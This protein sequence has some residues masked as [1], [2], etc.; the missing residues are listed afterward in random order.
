MSAQIY[1]IGDGQFLTSVI[2]SMALI[3]QSSSFTIL[4]ATGFLIGVLWVGVQGVMSGGR[5]FKIQ[6][7]FIAMLTWMVFFGSTTEAVIE[8]VKTSQVRV[9]ANVPV[10]IA[11]TGEVVSIVGRGLTELFEQAW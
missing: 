5:E 6:N 8:D 4:S 9:V 1:S 11:Y 3:T 2:D 10:G 7:I